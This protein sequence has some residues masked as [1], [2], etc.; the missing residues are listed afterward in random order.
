[1]SVAK[2]WDGAVLHPGAAAIN[3]GRVAAF[4]IKRDVE[5]FALANRFQGG[6]LLGRLRHRWNLNVRV[7]K[8]DVAAEF[9]SVET[10]RTALRF[11]R[12]HGAGGREQPR[13]GTPTDR[14]GDI[15]F[16]VY[17][18]SDGHTFDGGLGLHRS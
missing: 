4:T 11:G 2:I 14:S 12:G 10:N 18:T 15:L 7:W 13:S 8:R 6:F 1:R 3:A 9:E 16:S 5:F 17:R